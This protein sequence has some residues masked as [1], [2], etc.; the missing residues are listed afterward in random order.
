MRGRR[1]WDINTEIKETKQEDVV[2][3]HLAQDRRLMAGSSEYRN[4]PLD[5]I[6]W[7]RFLE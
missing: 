7:G 6:N 5:S 1:G 4:E 2:W 3:A